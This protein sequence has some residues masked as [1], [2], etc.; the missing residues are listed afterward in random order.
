MTGLSTGGVAAL[1]VAILRPDLFAAAVAITPDR[2]P[3]GLCRL[4]GVPVW[5]FQNARDVRVPP[6]HARSIA[7]AITA[8]GGTARLTMFQR[9]GHDA[10]SEAYVYPGLYDWIRSQRR[11]PSSPP[12]S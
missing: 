12:P 1:N 2:V 7:R 6:R 8:C 5:I 4:V 10:W 11:V 9:D 3:S